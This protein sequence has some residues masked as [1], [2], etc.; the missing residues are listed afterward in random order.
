MPAAGRTDEPATLEFV[1][2][3][4]KPVGLRPVLYIAGGLVLL[5]VAGVAF[6]IGL[7]LPPDRQPFALFIASTVLPTMGALAAF[8]AAFGLLRSPRR[9]TVGPTGLAVEWNGATRAWK[10]DEVGWAEVAAAPLSYRKT[11]S[12]YDPRGKK[13]VAV[14]PE[15]ADLD[16]IAESIKAEIGR[17]P[18][19]TAGRVQGRKARK[20]AAFLTLAGVAFLALAAANGI[21]S[22]QEE[23]AAERLADEGV[24]ADAAV[25]RVDLYN[26]TPRIEY[27]LTP[28]EGKTVT[29]DAMLTQEAFRELQGAETV[30]V[31]YVPGDPDNNRLVAGEVED[32]FGSPRSNLLLSIGV[33]VMA[34]L[35]LG[36]GAIQW[37]G[38]DIDLDSKTGKLSVKRFGTGR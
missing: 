23:V 37:A 32:Q 10:W 4:K 28:P 13:L 15:F 7:I 38:W 12:V 16:G 21:H 9:V 27:A 29:R 36:V 8:G 26:V 1:Y 31:R 3:L 33:G 19:D 18:D 35:F 34:L 22:R 14:G 24:E 30:R 5:G 6:L 25:K 17:K 20:S 2:E 11:L